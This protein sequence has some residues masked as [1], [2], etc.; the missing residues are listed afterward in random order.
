VSSSTVPIR[1]PFPYCWAEGTYLSVLLLML[2]LAHYWGID[3]VGVFVVP[4][5]LAMFLLRWLEKRA[6]R[7]ADSESEEPE[8]S[9]ESI[10]VG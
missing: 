4:V 6:R 5:V 1:E 8:E 2:T 7:R 9:E 10:D 3:E